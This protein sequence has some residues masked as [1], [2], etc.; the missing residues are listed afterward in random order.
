MNQFE[1]H[2]TLIENR[3]SNLQKES[4]SNEEIIDWIGK[5]REIKKEKIRDKI[6]KEKEIKEKINL[7]T[8]YGEIINIL[9]DEYIEITL[10]DKAFY[11]KIDNINE[12]YEKID[13]SIMLF[14]D[15][16]S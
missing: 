2:L 10:P 12:T 13:K 5:I 3:I 14:E 11:K 1:S 16:I 7:L 15:N 9:V 8:D 6:E 4:Y